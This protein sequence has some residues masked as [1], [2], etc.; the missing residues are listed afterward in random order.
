MKNFSFSLGLVV[1]TLACLSQSSFSALIFPATYR[2]WVLSDGTGNGALADN[3]YLATPN[4]S[5]NWFAFDLASEVPGTVTSAKLYLFNNGYWKN[6]G[7][8]GSG[9]YTLYDVSPASQA[10][11]NSGD[12]NP[13]IPVF[14]DLG[15]GT[16]YGSV[17]FS[18]AD[19]GHYM[20]LEL[21]ASGLS[22]LQ[23]A[24]GSSFFNIG[25]AA[26]GAGATFSYSASLDTYL[27]ITSTP[28]PEPGTWATAA[29]LL[30]SA[31]S[32]RWRKR[33]GMS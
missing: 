32:L 21:N 20:I 31:A 27:E 14:T 16:S 9:T 25:G 11:L 33:A 13:G 18:T 23:S 24:W 30:C 17:G 12:L 5:N 3:N 28:A 7:V 4:Q 1:L 22:D 26:T 29:L 6:P 19:N 2:G 10:I 15:S 8:W